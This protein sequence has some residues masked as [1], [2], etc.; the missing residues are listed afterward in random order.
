MLHGI[1]KGASIRY[2]GRTCERISCVP[3]VVE[4]FS[5]CGL[6][7]FSRRTDVAIAT[8]ANTHRI[9]ASSISENKL[10]QRGVA[11]GERC[12]KGTTP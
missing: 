7:T 8:F 12:P 2:T 9:S 5:A 1:A 11:T 3:C 10:D 4:R 6:I